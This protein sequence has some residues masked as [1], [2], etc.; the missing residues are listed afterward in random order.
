MENILQ[1]LETFIQANHLDKDVLITKEKDKLTLQL[2]A[3]LLK[4]EKKGYF[5]G[6]NDAKP[7]NEYKNE[8]TG[9]SN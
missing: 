2:Y 5:E 6:Y 3:L 1:K 9:E 4:A 8:R 7:K